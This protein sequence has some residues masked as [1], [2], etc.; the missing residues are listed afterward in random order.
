MSEER[1]ADEEQVLAALSDLPKRYLDELPIVSM[2]GVDGAP[3]WMGYEVAVWDL[4]EQL[5]EFLRFHKKIR[6]KTP[7]LDQVGR[8]V[9]DKRY[10]KGR[11]NFV[12]LLGQFGKEAYAQVIGSLL[13]DTDVYGHAIVSLNRAKVSGYLEDVTKILA[14]EKRG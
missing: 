11:Q 5:R 1:W 3:D 12:L 13:D 9:S 7:I 6:R 2:K 10:G 4:S 8:L 14:I